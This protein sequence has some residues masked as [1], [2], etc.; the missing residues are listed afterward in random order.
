M[1]P[2]EPA[3]HAEAPRGTLTDV[4]AQPDLRRLNLGV[5]VLPT[6]QRA[7]WVAVPARLVQAGAPK[8]D[9]W[10]IYLPAVVLSFI[11]MGGLF[12]M[13]RAGRLRAAL[14][15]AIALVLLVQP[16]SYTHLDVYKRQC[17]RRAPPPARCCRCRA[18]VAACRS[19]GR[20]R[21]GAS[22][23]WAR[24]ALSLIHI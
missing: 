24:P 17:L 21:A 12:A 8:Q 16:V 18:G 11:A 6:L 15:G 10:H 7:M 23:C 19:G 4:W 13:E 9:H 1:V 20:C 2:P 5:F 3:R 14:L 22:R